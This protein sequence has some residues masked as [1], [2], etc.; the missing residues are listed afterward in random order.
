[1]EALDAGASKVFAVADHQVAHVYVN[2]PSLLGKARDLAPRRRPEWPPCWGRR[3]RGG[4]AHRARA[5][6]GLGGR[7][8]GGRLVFLLLLGR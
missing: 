6:R 8:E 3:R 5:G 4:L 2:D 7:G 1:M